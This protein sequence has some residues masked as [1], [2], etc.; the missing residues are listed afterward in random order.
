MKRIQC[1]TAAA[2]LL[3]VNQLALAQVLAQAQGDLDGDGQNEIAIVTDTQRQSANDMGNIRTLEIFKVKNG[4]RQLWHKSEQVILP[5]NAGGMMG[6][7]FESIEIKNGSLFVFQS[8]GS[9]WKWGFR[10]QYRYQNGQFE[11]IGY[12]SNSGR[13]CDY[14]IDIDANL[15]TGKIVYKKLP[16]DSGCEPA[17]ERI[18]AIHETFTNKNVKLNFSNR[19]KQS[20]Y[21]IAPKSKEEIHFF[22]AP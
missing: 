12:Q 22:S 15:Q 1:L 20:V 4:K 8:G 5:S 2:L 11:L 9:S 6:D 18:K 14:W 16:D 21:V 13:V 17:G 7:P 10:D 19:R 3:S